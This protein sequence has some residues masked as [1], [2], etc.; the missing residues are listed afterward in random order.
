MCKIPKLEKLEL[1]A[2][3]YKDKYETWLLNQK[4]AIRRLDALSN[5]IELER[6]INRI[7]NRM[8]F[9]I[10]IIACVA[11]ISASL[12]KTLALV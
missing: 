9:I 10:G 1:N 6:E 12:L 11:L 3:E 4:L 8:L 2:E 5:Q 7:T